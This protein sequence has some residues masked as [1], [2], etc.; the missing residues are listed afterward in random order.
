[1]GGSKLLGNPYQETPLL[2]LHCSLTSKNHLSMS[3]KSAPVPFLPSLM[4]P[5]TRSKA[6]V[7]AGQPPLKPHV[8][9]RVYDIIT[10]KTTPSIGS[11]P[12]PPHTHDTAGNQDQTPRNSAKVANRG[13]V[14]QVE[15]ARSWDENRGAKL[16]AGEWSLST[17]M[18]PRRANL[19]A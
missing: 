16:N 7:Q 8:G 18:A 17:Y 10:V 4:M 5:H 11:V 12:P 3:Q 9:G 6:S 2:S 13:D 1:M 15:D 19:N 14:D